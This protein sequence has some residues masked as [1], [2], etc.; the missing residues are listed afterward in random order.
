M[1]NELFCVQEVFLSIQVSRILCRV[2]LVVV[3]LVQ[4]AFCHT[5]LAQIH[6]PTQTAKCQGLEK[7]DKSPKS[8]PN[9][10][11]SISRLYPRLSLS[12]SSSAE[13]Y[14]SHTPKATVPPSMKKNFKTLKR[15]LSLKV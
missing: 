2:T 11:K 3:K 9:S 15:I 1:C 13:S 8:N 5:L 14:H 12:N 6:S 4:M 7:Y 10:G